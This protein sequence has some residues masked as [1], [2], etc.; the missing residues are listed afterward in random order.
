MSGGFRD[1]ELDP[2]PRSPQVPRWPECRC[3]NVAR[4]ECMCEDDGLVTHGGTRIEGYDHGAFR[5]GAT[6][7][8]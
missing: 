1:G 5:D 6:V 7:R 8:A 3:Y 2:T 4:G